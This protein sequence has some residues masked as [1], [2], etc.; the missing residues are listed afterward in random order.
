MFSIS[1]LENE[2]ATMCKFT[3]VKTPEKALSKKP[4]LDRICN[5]LGVTYDMLKDK[6]REHF[7][8][9]RRMVAFRFIRDNY[10]LTLKEIGSLFNRDHTTVIHGLNTFDDLYETNKKFRELANKL[11]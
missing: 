4:D 1:Q 10:E 8:T 6:S 3:H 5:L 11:I 2:L 9:T 7:L